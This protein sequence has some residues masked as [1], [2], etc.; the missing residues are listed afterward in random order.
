MIK[1]G[2][3]RLVSYDVH[4]LVHNNPTIRKDVTYFENCLL[5]MYK[6]SVNELRTNIGLFEVF[7]LYSTTNNPIYTQIWHP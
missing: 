6:S 5:N 3:Y 2:Y 7:V 4:F 1:T